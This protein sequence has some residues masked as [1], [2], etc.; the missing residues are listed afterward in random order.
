MHTE[1]LVTVCERERQ[2]VYCTDSWERGEGK[3]FMNVV[4][5]TWYISINNCTVT[6]ICPLKHLVLIFKSLRWQL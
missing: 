1:I 3:M 5:I 2:L 4:Y 6:V